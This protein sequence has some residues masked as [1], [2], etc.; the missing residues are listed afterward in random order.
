MNENIIKLIVSDFD[1]TLVKA[2]LPE[3]GKLEWENFYKKKYPHNGWWSK[4]ESLDYNAL[5]FK[6]NYNIVNSINNETISGKTYIMLLTSRIDI[7]KNDIKNI[8]D[9]KININFNYLDLKN[10]E[11][12]KGNRLLNHI[13]E[14]PNLKEIIIYEDNI[15]DIKSYIDI[16]HD[17][18][19]NITFKIYKVLNGNIELI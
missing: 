17:I 10:N 2:V 7:L 15:M 19:S 5:N 8:L 4:S 1:D 9:N 6:V 18:S 11:L 12:N 3:L 14:F 13:N 16:I